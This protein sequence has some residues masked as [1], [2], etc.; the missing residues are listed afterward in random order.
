MSAISL[1]VPCGLIAAASVPLMLKI[2]P[3]NRLY[4]FRTR[5]TLANRDLWFRANRF[6][7][8]AHFIASAI[9][10]GVFALTPEYASGQDFAGLMVLLVPQ[11]AA[12]AASFAYA[13]AIGNGTP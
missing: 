13:R 6:A 3:P 1:Y 10:A 8:C 7:G 2:V 11:V 12:L 5:Q 4:G 9:T